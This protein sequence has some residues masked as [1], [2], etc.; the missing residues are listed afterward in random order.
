MAIKTLLLAAILALPLPAVVNAA[1]IYADSVTAFLGPQSE[2]VRR[3]GK[4]AL[5]ASDGTFLSLGFGGAAVF[6]F[7][8][9][10]T[11]PASFL[12][13]TWGRREGYRESARVFVGNI[14]DSRKSVFTASDFTAIREITNA[15]AASSLAF[16]GKW[17]YLA[18]LDTSPRVT[19]RDGFD[20]DSVSVTTFP[21]AATIAPVPL[22]ASGLILF[23]GMLALIGWRRSHAV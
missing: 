15:E 21:L 10:F 20:I 16:D 9:A 12:E 2:G 11:G 18:I 5:G 3:D 17:K 19:G 6:A 4:S 13:V 14:F 7:E 22:P 23:G 8:Q 1:T